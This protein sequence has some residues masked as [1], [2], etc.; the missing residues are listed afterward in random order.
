MQKGACFGFCLVSPLCYLLQGFHRIH[1]HVRCICTVLANPNHAGTQTACVALAK[2]IYIRV[3]VRSFWQGIHLIY[4]HLRCVHT[5][6]A[7]PIY[8]VCNKIIRS[9]IRHVW[10]IPAIAGAGGML[11]PCTASWL[12]TSA[13]TRRAYHRPTSVIRWVPLCAERW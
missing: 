12:K 9:V 5:V 4:G 1:G 2:T 3:Y 7:N 10:L 11:A 13:T 6:L 8:L